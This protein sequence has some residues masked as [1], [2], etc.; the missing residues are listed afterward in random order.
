MNNLLD[1]DRTGEGYG[2]S[3]KSDQRVRSPKGTAVT[4][5]PGLADDIEE[6]YDDD[7]E[8]EEDKN[9]NPWIRCCKTIDCLPISMYLLDFSPL[10]LRFRFI[11]RIDS[12]LLSCETCR[13]L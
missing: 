7:I 13:W 10:T 12:M 9:T 4:N 8:F 5:Q 11:Y 2:L 1:S 6:E 3:R